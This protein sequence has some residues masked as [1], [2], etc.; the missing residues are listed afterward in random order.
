MIPRCARA[1][2]PR[3]GRRGFVH[4]LAAGALQGLPRLAYAG[5]QLE[6]PLADAVRSAKTY[7][8]LA[9]AA[10]DRLSVGSG[11]GPVQHFH[12]AW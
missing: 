4:G 11:H 7:V 9:I 5:A 12:R 10:A 8:T 3:F 6:E 2:E 1:N